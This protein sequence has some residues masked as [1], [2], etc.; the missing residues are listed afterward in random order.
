VLERLQ[1]STTKANQRLLLQLEFDGLS[2]LGAS[3]LQSLQANIPRYRYLREEVSP[4]SRF[5]QYD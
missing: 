1:T 3:S 2:R 5:P 4:P